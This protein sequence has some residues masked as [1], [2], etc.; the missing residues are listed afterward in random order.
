VLGIL[1]ALATAG[2]Y[3]GLAG[4]RFISLDDGR[5]VTANPRVAAGITWGGVVWAF[6]TW[7]AGNWHPLTWL[8]HMVDVQVFGLNPTGHHLV[9]L[10]WHCANTALVFAVL[11]RLTGARWRSAAVAALFGIHPLHVESVAWV[12][13]RK[14]LL[15]TFFGLLALGA[16]GSYARRPGVGRYTTVAVALTASLLSKP[17]LVSLPFVLL[18]LDVWPLGRLAGATR[19]GRRLPR[20]LLEKLP[21]LTLAAASGVVT[22]LAQRGWGAVKPLAVLPASVRL[23]N[24]AMSYVV[25]L[26]KTIWP[27]DL[28]V[29]YPHADA[30]PPPWQIAAAGLLLTALSLVAARQVRRRPFLL[31]GWLWYLGTLVPVIGL[32]QVGGQALADRYTYVPLIGV[33]L[34]LSWGA[35]DLARRHRGGAAIL[36]A[37]AAAAIIALASVTWGQVRHWRDTASLFG[38]AVSVTEG[39]WMAFA[40]LGKDA[41]DAGRPAEAVAHLRR[42]LTINPYTTA[43]AGIHTNLARALANTGDLEEA[44]EEYRRALS[45]DSSSERARRELA[46]ILAA[47]PQRLLEQR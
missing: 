32:V 47:R 21:L 23:T 3:A 2:V 22:F 13:E 41:L 29:Y 1:L 5:Y 18:L 9:N 33:F 26:K 28:A 42:S 30:L 39:N 6:T 15:A 46:A 40:L 27:T 14:D 34:A 37:T 4:H 17:M 12:A 20:L 11:L 38:H 36:G 25:Y 7:H 19:P 31:T 16:Y 43:A 24:A 45:I 44:I 35:A 10:A 8:S